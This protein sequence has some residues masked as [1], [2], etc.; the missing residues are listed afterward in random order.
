MILSK[1]SIDYLRRPGVNLVRE[2]EKLRKGICTGEK[3]LTFGVTAKKADL[4]EGEKIPSRINGVL[5][6]VIEVGPFK[7]HSADPK[8]KYRPVVG[9]V[10]GC[11]GTGVMATFGGVVRDKTTGRLVGVTNNHA[12][13]LRYDPD[14]ATPTGG[15]L[16]TAGLLFLQPSHGDGGS[17]EDDVLGPILRAPAMRFGLGVETPPNLV[18]AAL[19]SLE[20][21]NLAW[22][23]TLNLHA[24]PFPFARKA[25]WP[26]GATVA[27]S[28]R[29]TSMTTGT[30]TTKS[31]AVTVEFGAGDHNK[32]IFAG[33]ILIEG[34]GFGL[35]GDSGSLVVAIIGGV[36]RI[37]GLYFAGDGTSVCLANHIQD[38]ENALQIE[39]WDGT[40]VL[41]RSLVPEV[42]V[43]ST[44]FLRQSDTPFVVTHEVD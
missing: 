28:G 13:G 18:D 38:V 36:I 27:K 9:G 5:T 16:F 33:Q 10:S 6:D 1:R 34:A 35:P 32:A 3:C 15:N 20:E 24:G 44:A 7:A 4:P 29:T 37:I 11:V 14:Y 31:A 23:N 12:G 17:S 30:V 22:F 8:L 42:L 25:T 40:V 21:L 41:P 43:N 39:S 2:G 19:I 26:V